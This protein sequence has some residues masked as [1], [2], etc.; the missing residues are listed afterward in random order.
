MTTFY[1]SLA[2][3]LTYHAD[4]GNAA[5]AASTDELRTAALAR[6]S[7]YIDGQYLALFPGMKTNGRLQALQWPRAGAIDQN[8]YGILSEEIPVEIINAT[9]EGALRELVVPNSLAPDIEAGGGQLKREK[10]G[11]LEFEYLRDGTLYAT[12]RAIEN[13]LVNLLGARSRFSATASRG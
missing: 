6:T 11:P 12:Y 3:A 7:V 13:A 10:I 1:G 4:H 8:G 2:G 5:W 9:Y